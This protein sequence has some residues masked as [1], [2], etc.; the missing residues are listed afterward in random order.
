MK[1]CLLWEAQ[2]GKSVKGPPPEEEAM[3][4]TMCDKQAATPVPSPPAQLG[5]R[6]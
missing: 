6:R 3:A 4:D 2:Q 1:D 5:F